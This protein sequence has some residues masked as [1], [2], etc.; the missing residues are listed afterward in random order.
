MAIYAN[1]KKPRSGWDCT[2]TASY[3]QLNA[4]PSCCSAWP[5]HPRRANP[6][7]PRRSPRIWGSA[8]IPGP[9]PMLPPSSP[10]TC[11][12]WPPTANSRCGWWGTRWNCWNSGPWSCCNPWWMPRRWANPPRANS[13]RANAR[14][15]APGGQ[16][17]RRARRPW[18]ASAESCCRVCWPARR[19]KAPPF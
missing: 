13:T 15:S 17:A 11:N 6:D 5:G 14:P 9:M 7:L 2:S 8:W 1:S 19:P 12:C 16:R 18:S 10:R 3:Q 4:S